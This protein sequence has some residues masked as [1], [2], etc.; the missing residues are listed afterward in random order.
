LISSLALL[1]L[2]Q[3]PATFLLEQTEVLIRDTLACFARQGTLR[4]ALATS[5]VLVGS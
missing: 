3:H 2:R 1:R 4:G 5:R